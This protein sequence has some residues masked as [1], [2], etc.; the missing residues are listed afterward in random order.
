MEIA[1]A[2]PAPM[3]ETRDGGEEVSR[4]L[5]QLIEEVVGR[6]VMYG[7]VEGKRRGS[8]ASGDQAGNRRSRSVRLCMEEP[9][10]VRPVSGVW[11]IS[12]MTPT[13][14]RFDEEKMRGMNVS[15][16]TYVLSHKGSVW[17]VYML[18]CCV[19]VLLP[20][21]SSHLPTQCQ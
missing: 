13:A 5:E 20:L 3:L 12:S 6:K 14:S 15:F 1:S 21:R 2:F 8:V 9:A 16:S 19:L 18:L 10:K 11:A 4:D 7:F 17:L